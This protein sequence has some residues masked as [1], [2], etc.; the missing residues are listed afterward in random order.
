[1]LNICLLFVTNVTI[2]K[3]IMDKSFT[4][5]V[6][7]ELHKY[8]FSSQ[9]VTSP[10]PYY[11]KHHP[12]AEGVSQS[13]VIKASE[14]LPMPYIKLSV[15]VY[16]LSGLKHISVRTLAGIVGSFLNWDMN[17]EIASEKYLEYKSKI[18]KTVKE[19]KVKTDGNKE[20]IN[21][22]KI[23]FL[24]QILLVHNYSNQVATYLTY[25]ALVKHVGKHLV[26]SGLGVVEVTPDKREEIEALYNATMDLSSLDAV[27]KYY[28]KQDFRVGS[29]LINR[30]A[31]K[32]I[33]SRYALYNCKDN[34]ES[35]E[36]F[37]HQINK[38]IG[39]SKYKSLPNITAIIEYDP[40]EIMTTMGEDF[41]TGFRNIR[42]CEIY[43]QMAITANFKNILGLKNIS[44]ESNL[45]KE[46]GVSNV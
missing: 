44:F 31:I 33:I 15:P 38:F 23:N 2:R 45:L 14:L 36:I 40:V 3:P 10:L 1:M 35:I 7:L 20:D 19:Y 16:L 17:S 30:L 29:I 21:K 39:I 26:S 37:L 28:L 22:L 12:S 32:K 27:S 11:V 9:D 5:S 4:T 18:T 34:P 6:Y 8:L 46:D 43:L 13:D 41:P 24:E 25:K 42:T